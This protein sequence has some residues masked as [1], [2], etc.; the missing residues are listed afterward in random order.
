[1]EDKGIKRKESNWKED[2]E[3]LVEEFKP[4]LLAVSSTEDMGTW[5]ANT[6]SFRGI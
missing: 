5:N 3:E 2:L 6:F 1:M 4:D